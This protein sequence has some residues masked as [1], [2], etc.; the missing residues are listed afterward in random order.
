MITVLYDGKCGLCRHEISFYR[1]IAPDGRFTWVDVMT[2]DA[3]LA[4]LKVHR[5]DALM[6]IHVFDDKGQCLTGAD[7]FAALWKGIPG[8]RWLGHLVSL[9]VIRP[10]ARGLYAAFGYLR[11]RLHGYDRC[12]L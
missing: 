11:F 8:F 3:A 5:K 2:D 7:A 1:K 12:D 10:V 6:A 4:D 9:P